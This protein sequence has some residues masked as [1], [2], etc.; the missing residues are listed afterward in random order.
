MQYIGAMRTGPGR[1]MSEVIDGRS[2]GSARSTRSRVSRSDELD[3]GILKSTADFRETDED[4]FLGRLRQS[5]RENLRLVV[6]S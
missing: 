5:D 3:P 6:L 1:L 4:S 2:I